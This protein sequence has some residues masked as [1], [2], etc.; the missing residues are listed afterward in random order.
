VADLPLEEA[1]G[2]LLQQQQ[3]CVLLWVHKI[4]RNIKKT[5]HYRF[6]YLEQ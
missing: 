6:L 2:N 5:F 1:K 3:F 4:C